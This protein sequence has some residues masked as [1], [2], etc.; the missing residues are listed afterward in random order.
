MKKQLALAATDKE[1]LYEKKRDPEMS[2]TFI[3]P[4]NKI[5]TQ[6]SLRENERRRLQ[7][8][9]RTY[10][11]NLLPDRKGSERI[12]GKGIPRAQ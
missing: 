2:N 12:H 7:Q 10:L 9:T 3:S 8:K 6:M 11:G 4:T 1:N 5:N